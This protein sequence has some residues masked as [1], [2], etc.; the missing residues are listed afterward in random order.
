MGFEGWEYS[1]NNKNTF[2]KNINIY[3]WVAVH[4]GAHCIPLEEDNEV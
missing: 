3:K 1:K 4:D 2:E